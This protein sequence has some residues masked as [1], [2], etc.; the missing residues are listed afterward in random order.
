MGDLP[1]RTPRH[2]RHGGPLPLHLANATRANLFPPSR[3]F[4][5]PGCPGPAHGV[6]DRVSTACP[7]GRGMLLTRYAQEALLLPALPLDLHVLSLPL[8]FILSQDQTLHC[9]CFLISLACPALKRIF[10]SVFVLLSSSIPINFSQNPASPKPS[11]PFGTAK[12]LTFATTPNFFYF[13]SYFFSRPAPGATGPVPGGLSAP[14]GQAREPPL[15]VTLY[16]PD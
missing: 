9:I 5:G 15:K 2:R 1:L 10:V 3:A 11:F 16:R 8:A 4:T 14:P 7:P 13:F 6:L 12:I